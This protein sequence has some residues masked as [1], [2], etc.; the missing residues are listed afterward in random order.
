MK[1]VFVALSLANIE[2]TKIH[3][4]AI[5]SSA[6]FFFWVKQKADEFV[7]GLP[8]YWDG[9]DSEQ[10]HKVRS[11]AGRLANLAAPW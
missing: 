10:A 11:F 4:S 3:T 6:G 7:V 8:K 5:E 9:K 1:L 2:Y